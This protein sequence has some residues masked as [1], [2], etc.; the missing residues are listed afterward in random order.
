MVE[1]GDVDGLAQAV[2]SVMQDPQHAARLGEAAQARVTG[3][4][5]LAREA[6]G[7][8]RVYRG[9]FEKAFD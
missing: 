2:L 8:A 9:L 6:E 1:T 7:I 5:S 3:H 4:F